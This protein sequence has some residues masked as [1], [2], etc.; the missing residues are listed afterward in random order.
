MFEEIKE[1]LDYFDKCIEKCCPEDSLYCHLDMPFCAVRHGASIRA[2]IWYGFKRFNWH[3]RRKFLTDKRYIRKMRRIGRGVDRGIMLDKKR[4]LTAYAPYINRKWIDTADCTEEQIRD[5][6]SSHGTVMI[7]PYDKLGGEGVHKYTYSEESFK[8]FLAE[9]P[10]SLVEQLI[11][12]HPKLNALN[13]NSVNTVRVVTYADKGEVGIVAAILRMGIST[14]CVDNLCSGGTV[15]VI[16]LDSG[17][18][19]TPAINLDQDVYLES[20]MTG[21]KIIGMEIPNWETAKA[22]A[23]KFA[24]LHP[25]IKYVGWDVAI[26]EDAVE[27]IEANPHSH[28][29]LMQ[30]PDKIGKRDLEG[31]A[32]RSP[33][34]IKY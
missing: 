2:Y 10:G 11:I 9:N 14:A 19:V 8:D 12:Q 27:I 28:I 23:L 1:R 24:A 25:E 5:F 3:E 13:P 7:K 17:V 15:S 21:E 20:P 22:T 4:F 29:G 33:D 32:H 16:D 30:M 18:V 26:T 34:K 31:F 6:V